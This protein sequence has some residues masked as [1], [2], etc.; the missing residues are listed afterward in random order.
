MRWNEQDIPDRTGWVAVITG[1]NGGLGLASARALAAKGAHVVMA[2][3]N[4]AKAEAVRDRILGDVPHASL[5][6][7]GLDLGE[8]ASVDAAAATIR[9]RHATL[10]L[11]IN[12]AGVTARLLP[13]LARSQA[14]RVVA[15]SSTGRH[16]GR[17]LDPEDPFREG[18]YDPWRAYGDPK[19]ANLLFA[20]EL[21]SRLREAGARV[22]SLVA[23]PGLSATDL[24]ASRSRDRGRQL[25]A[26][27]EALKG[28]A[29]DV[30]TLVADAP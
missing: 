24:Q 19:L 9:E 2:A 22:A 16:V 4:A 11:L 8:L 26:V 1:A 25:W 27:S 29:F 30:P 14:A 3:R 18:R 5:E 23:H 17:V 20:V 7:V 6:I 28:I 15:V 21:E 13:A 10:D 12:N